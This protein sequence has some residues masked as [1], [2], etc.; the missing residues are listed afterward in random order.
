MFSTFP[1]KETYHDEKNK[2]KFVFQFEN[3]STKNRFFKLE[4]APFNVKVKFINFINFPSSKPK[5]KEDKKA[6]KS[7]PFV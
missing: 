2:T 5:K 1:S 3:F 6:K 7:Y 4:R